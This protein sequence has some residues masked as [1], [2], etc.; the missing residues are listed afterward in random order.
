MCEILG[1]LRCIAKSSLLC[2]VARRQMGSLLPTFRQNVSVPSSRIK[3]SK[4]N[5]FGHKFFL[6][7]L[8]LEDGANTLSRN[9]GSELL[10]DTAQHPRRTNISVSYSLLDY[11]LIRRNSDIKSPKHVHAQR[12]ARFVS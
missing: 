10:T 7:V 11:L 2:N 12:Y 3:V 9:V 8:T 6:D 4:K 1:F 5:Y